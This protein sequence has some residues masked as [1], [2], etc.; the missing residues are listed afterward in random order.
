VRE[1]I[2]RVDGRSGEV[3]GE[4]GFGYPS[5]LRGHCRT[6]SSLRLITV[7]KEREF[8][9]TCLFEGDVCSRRRKD[10]GQESDLPKLD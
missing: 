5:I 10:L 4:E 9:L 2:G 6:L 3:Q 8:F 7:L 1:N